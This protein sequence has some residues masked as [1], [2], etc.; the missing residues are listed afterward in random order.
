ML[1]D[2]YCACFT[3]KPIEMLCSLVIW[4][5]YSLSKWD[6]ISEYMFKKTKPNPNW[7]YGGKGEVFRGS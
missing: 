1:Q 2:F 5:Y 6:C 4:G 7:G 3:G